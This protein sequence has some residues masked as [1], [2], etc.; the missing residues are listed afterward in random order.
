MSYRLY[1]AATNAVWLASGWALKL[2]A[3]GS[4]P[5]AERLGDLPSVPPGSIWM[6]AASVGEV[7][8]ALPLVR[9][10]RSGGEA[11]LL[12][13]VTPTG[14]RVAEEQVPEGV[15]VAHPPLDFVSPVRAALDRVR[16]RALLLV[17]TEIWPTLAFEAAAAGALVGIV[18]GRLSERSAR[19][20]RG[21]GSPLQGAL[22]SVS[23]VACRSEADRRRFVAVGLPEGAV[24]VVGNMKFDTD[25]GPPCE[26]RRRETRDAL[27]VPAGARVVVYGCVRPTEEETVAEA[28]ASIDTEFPGVWQIVAP[29]HLERVEPLTGR[30]AGAGVSAV[31]RS[32]ELTARPP[33]RVIVLDTTGELKAVY[34]I[35][36]VAF[37]GGTLAP[38]GG[39]NPLEPAAQGVPVVLGPHTENCAE[40]ARALVEGGGAV[41]VRSREELVRTVGELLRDEGL[42]TSA[43]DRALRVVQRGGGATE[44]TLE[45]LA[46]E[47]VLDEGRE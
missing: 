37:V 15:E 19:Y 44:R 11:V 39:H 16:P 41:I 22:E 30:L 9:A 1:R 47:G 35:A 46:R 31:T 8:A 38:Y 36:C 26:D 5:W 13:V 28:V 43:A 29:R 45:I 14:R 24:E 12:T 6:H 21:A 23:F 4:T 3:R 25:S 27:G 42:R 7:S 33:S 40:A 2:R 34:S 32:L 20:Y 17:E 10:L 18:N